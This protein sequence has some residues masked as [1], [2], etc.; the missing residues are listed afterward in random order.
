M[1]DRKTDG[2]T[3]GQTH[4][5]TPHDGIGRSMHIS[6]ARKKNKEI[7]VIIMLHS[8]QCDKLSANNLI[9]TPCLF[10][11]FQFDKEYFW[12]TGLTMM[13]AIDKSLAYHKPLVQLEI[14]TFLNKIV[15]SPSIVN[16][17]VISWLVNCPSSLLKCRISHIRPA[18]EN[19]ITSFAVVIRISKTYIH[20]LTTMVRKCNFAVSITII[21]L[22]IVL[23]SVCVLIK[24]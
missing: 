11:D 7:N 15:A 6:V 24:L 13:L 5:Q 4:R 1:T 19:N 12:N 20:F 23:M 14:T 16:G 8:L 3:D 17:S 2:R 9:H 21:G 10:I 22:I 18:H